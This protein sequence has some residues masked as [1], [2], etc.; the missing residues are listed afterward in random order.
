VTTA[1][2]R[3]GAA[4]EPGVLGTPEVRFARRTSLGL[5]LWPSVG[6]CAVGWWFRTMGPWVSIYSFRQEQFGGMGAV[7]RLTGVIP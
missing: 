5:R 4:P 2:S 3:R 1:H 6:R 7:T